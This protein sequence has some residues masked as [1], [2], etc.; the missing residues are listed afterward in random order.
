AGTLAFVLALVGS[1]SA[2]LAVAYT[3][4]VRPDSSGRRDVGAIPKKERTQAA[5]LTWCLAPLVVAVCLLSTA[6]LWGVRWQL[7]PDGQVPYLYA[8]A[9]GAAIH[10]VGFFIAAAFSKWTWRPKPR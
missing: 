5:F 6:V 4:R 8:A 10:T 2:A 1:L 3:H 7:L 9:I